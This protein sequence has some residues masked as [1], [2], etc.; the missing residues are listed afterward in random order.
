VVAIRLQTTE[1]EHAMDPIHVSRIAYIRQQ[2]F[3]EQAQYDDLRW[4]RKVRQHIGYWLVLIGNKMRASA[5]TEEAVPCPDGVPENY[6][7]IGS[8]T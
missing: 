8:L 5:S 7:S 6:K 1:G 4:I 3:W 2:E